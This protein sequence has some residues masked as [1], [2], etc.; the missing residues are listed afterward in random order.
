VSTPLS[1][2]TCEFTEASDCNK[3]PRASPHGLH[4]WHIPHHRIL[5]E[6][7]NTGWCCSEV[8]RP[9]PHIKEAQGLAAGDT[10]SSHTCTASLC[11]VSKPT[12]GS[13]A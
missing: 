7:M 4:A 12:T 2:H 8:C 10:Q 5:A 11:A 6:R 13:L 1:A 9:A 3:P